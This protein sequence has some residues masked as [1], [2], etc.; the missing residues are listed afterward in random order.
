MTETKPNFDPRYDPRFQRGWVEPEGGADAPPH[1]DPPSHRQAPQQA[2]PARL[3]PE[4]AEDPAHDPAPAR[5]EDLFAELIAPESSEP[6]DPRDPRGGREQSQLAPRGGA[7]LPEVQVAGFAPSSNG[8]PVEASDLV[9]PES[10][11]RVTARWLWLVL[12][13][14]VVFVVVGALAYWQSITQQNPYTGAISSMDQATLLILSQV[15]PGAVEIGVIG[16]V[17]SLVGWVIIGQ[18]AG[19]RRAGETSTAADAAAPGRQVDP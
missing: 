15:A 16:I 8:V 19:S 2:R 11:R 18:A 5:A 7:G 9:P 3:A 1:V 4:S 12:G 10:V 6:R 13:L 14:S 17:A